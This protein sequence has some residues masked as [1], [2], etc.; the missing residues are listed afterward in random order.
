[1]LNTE[2]IEYIVKKT[3]KEMRAAGMIREGYKPVTQRTEE[4]LSYYPKLKISNKPYTIEAV[5]K[6]EAALNTIRD[7]QYYEII[8][9]YYFQNLSREIIAEHFNTNEKTIT[10]N[11]RRLLKSLSVVIYSDDVVSELLEPME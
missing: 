8:D 3:I 10:R 4:L 7:D 2:E 9:L 11:R 1:M 5:K 6:I